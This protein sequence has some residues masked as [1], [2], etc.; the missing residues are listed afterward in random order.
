MKKLLIIF[1]IALLFCACGELPGKYKV[2]YH[3]SGEETSGFPPVDN[4]EYTSGSYADV[5]DQHSLLYS[6]HTFGGWNTKQ[7]KSGTNYN[8][9]DKIEIKNINIFLY[10]VWN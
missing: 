4:N 2:I 10:A 1:C 7:D 8:P 6:G 3:A 9:G 5:L